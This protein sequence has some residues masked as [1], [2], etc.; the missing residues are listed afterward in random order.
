MLSHCSLTQNAAATVISFYAGLSDSAAA[1]SSGSAP[2]VLT[3]TN[4]FRQCATVAKKIAPYAP[5]TADDA[6]LTDPDTLAAAAVN[7]SSSVLPRDAFIGD[8]QF[9][10]RSVA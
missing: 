10:S 4:S 9:D 6:N 8:Y 7:A 1:L 3:I 2:D 5:V